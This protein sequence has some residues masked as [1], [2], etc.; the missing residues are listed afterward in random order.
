M[1][2]NKD[3]VEKRKL[4]VEAKQ[5]LDT[6]SD[7]DILQKMENGDL[8]PGQQIWIFH[9]RETDCH[10]NRWNCI[11]CI[12]PY[13]HVVVF[14]GS[15]RANSKQGD[16]KVVHEVV[17][18]SKSWKCCTMMKAEIRREDIMKVWGNYN[19]MR[20]VFIPTNL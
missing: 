12:N 15:K 17:H 20:L 9:N 18:V 4:V 16:G 5:E 6:F 10:W 13:A 14:V 11:A 19:S 2:V 1:K 3:Y 8:E 7:S